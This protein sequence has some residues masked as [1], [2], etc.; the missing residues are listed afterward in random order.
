MGLLDF[1]TGGS[2]QDRFAKEVIA[3][4]RAR[5]WTGD[6]RHDRGGFSIALGEDSISLLDAFLERAKQNRARRAEAVDELATMALM[7]AEPPP[8]TLGEVADKLLPVIRTRVHVGEMWLVRPA[9]AQVRRRRCHSPISDSL[10]AWA[11]VELGLGMRGVGDEDLERWGVGVDEV[12]AIAVN[13]L[14]ARSMPMKFEKDPRGFY[15]SRYHDHYDV[16][17]LLLPDLLQT[18]PLNGDPVVLAPER[19]TLVVAGSEDSQAL[20]AMGAQLESVLGSMQ[21]LISMEALVYREGAWR[22]V[23]VTNASRSLGRLAMLGADLNHEQ[24]RRLLTHEFAEAGRE[25]YAAELTL[26][27][28]E[29]GATWSPIAFGKTALAPLADAYLLS[30]GEP[31]GDI[32]RARSDFEA[33]CGPFGREPDCWPERLVIDRAPTEAQW[34]QLQTAGV[35]EGFEALQAQF[36]AIR[37]AR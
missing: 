36:A 9:W 35:P 21:R 17:R 34:A 30:S 33:I 3:R 14:R 27:D 11:A 7:S 18:L 13:N 4:I 10:C 8:A 23:G 16:S 32:V 19:D 20:E 2:P 15:T 31:G 37:K 1:L 6:I 28:A 24:Q 26:L 29:E 5:G 22:P 25:A 12:L